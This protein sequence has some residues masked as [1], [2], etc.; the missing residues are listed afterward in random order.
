MDALAQSAHTTL[1]SGAALQAIPKR[2]RKIVLVE[3]NSADRNFSIY[4]SAS[5]FQWTFPSPLKDV[6]RIDVVEGSLPVPR[7]NMDKGW[8]E[9]TFQENN[10]R[11]NIVLT[12]GQYTVSSICSE[13]QT[14]LNSVA[15]STYTVSI[16]S[17][18]TGFLQIAQT[19]GPSVPF[20]LL[21]GTGDHVDTFETFPDAY[22]K[23]NDTQGLVKIGSPA[24]ALGFLS[25]KDVFAPGGGSPLMGVYPPD[26]DFILKRM[27]LYFNFDTTIDLRSIKRGLGRSEPSGIFYCDGDSPP[28]GMK[29]LSKDVWNNTIY[30]GPAPIS[31]IRSLQVDLRDEFGELLNLNG[32]EMT[33]LLE[34]TM[35]E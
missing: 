30:P 25:S 35:L 27:Y 22:V 10:V 14:K 8:N 15:S 3:V 16:P 26:L 11:F 18:I 5:S 12:P 29:F 2:R 6:E 1:G 33:L 13:L 21:F 7:Y 31:R 20:G 4:P 23:R 9:F 28:G 32:R 19:G 34:I 24:K 17:S